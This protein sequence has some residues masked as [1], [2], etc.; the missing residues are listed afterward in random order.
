MFCKYCNADLKPSDKVCPVCEK[1]INDL[2]EN[3]DMVDNKPENLEEIDPSLFTPLGSPEMVKETEQSTLN[4]TTEDVNLIQ[5][6]DNNSIPKPLEFSQSNN[7]TVDSVVEEENNESKNPMSFIPFIIL[8]FAVA[9]FGFGFIISRSP[10]MLFNTLINRSYKTINSNIVSDVDNMKG[11]FTLETSILTADK[12]TNSVL[13][14]L[15]NI[16]IG[17][18]YEVDY[19]HETVLTK[20]NSKY[21]DEKLLDVDVYAKDNNGYI[22]LNDIHDKYLSTKIDGLEEIF[23][24]VEMDDEHKILISEI[25]KA[26]TKSLK[27]D[28]FIQ[29]KE[30]I[31]I[32]EKNITTTKN[33]LVLTEELINN[34][35]KDIIIYLK[36]SNKFITS[37]SEVL[38]INKAET[39]NRMEEILESLDSTI[40]GNNNTKV[41]ISIYTKGLMNEVVKIDLETEESSEKAVIEFMKNFKD[42]YS[43]KMTSAGV[44]ISG[45]IKILKDGKIEVSIT[46]P[47]SGTIITITVSYLVEYNTPLTKVDVGNSVSIESLTEGEYNKIMTKLMENKGIQNLIGIINNLGFSNDF[48]HTAEYD[49]MDEYGNGYTCGE[50]IACSFD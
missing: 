43:I 42:D 29:T 14:I 24:K 20:I 10:K 37:L 38:E 4:S 3:V 30:D 45:N 6:N 16:Y 44:T 18:E 36:E 17:A 47:T 5:E 13:E 39:L 9:I 12:S 28:Y 40:P 50:G 22:L 7:I 31:I 35:E 26:L 32:N 19:E 23:E 11:K 46:D 25:K 48:D 8:I 15:N 41:I 27:S 49:Y 2:E 34:I 1:P 21:A 33:S